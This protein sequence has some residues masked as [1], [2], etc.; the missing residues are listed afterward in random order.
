MPSDSDFKGLEIYTAT[1]EDAT[2]LAAHVNA[3]YRGETSRA[4]WTTE[5]DLVSGTRTTADQLADEMKLPNVRFEVM[6]DREGKILASV[7]L[8]LED[9][10]ESGESA[11]GTAGAEGVDSS[12]V[13]GRVCYLGML[14]VRP[15]KQGGGLGRRMLEHS[16][17]IAR[18][19]G[20]PKI[21]MTVIDRRTELLAYYE[22]RGYV[23]TGVEH[24]F[25][26]DD[27]RFGVAAVPLKM[28][29]LEK[30]IR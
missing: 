21:R 9:V 29:E 8:V 16:E 18:A 6:R 26:F 22:R 4:G 12:H 14:T 5:A 11:I 13:R 7:E 20:C 2:D 1:A 27:P 15:T 24:P 19:W 28:V 10:P 3:A 23:R 25:H 17:A 30:K